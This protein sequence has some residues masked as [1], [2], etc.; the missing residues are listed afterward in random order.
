MTSTSAP[1]L[2]VIITT[3]NRRRTLGA[4]LRSLER[5]TYQT[6]DRQRLEV[7]VVDDGSTDGTTGMLARYR[8]PLTLQPL[9][10][11]LGP[12]EYGYLLALNIGLQQAHGPYAV[13]LDS[14]MVLHREALERMMATHAR[15]EAQG[16]QVA[17]RGWWARRKHPLKLWLRG[18]HLR[19]YRPERAAR[20][21]RHRKLRQLLAHR[22]RLSP[23]E[24][25]SAFLSVPTELAR[26]AGGF[27]GHVRRY[28]MDGEFQARL[29]ERFATRL[30]LEP[31]A[32]AIHGP[33]RGDVRATRYRHTRYKGDAGQG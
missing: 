20:A 29:Q 17:V 28:G 1:E 4:V 3:F 21:R 8:G 9:A 7:L 23:Q 10:S 15:W 14:D 19:N 11:G 18:D 5:Q 26:R 13:F 24:A 22:D 6:Y 30:V 2:S 16:E 33:L 25:H 31:G 12:D 27:A 32:Y